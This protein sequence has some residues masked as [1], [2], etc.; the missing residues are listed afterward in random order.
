VNHGQLDLGASR[1][2]LEACEGRAGVVRRHDPVARGERGRQDVL[3]PRPGVGGVAVDT[4]VHS[5]EHAVRNQGA[6]VLPGHSELV[7]V[8]DGEEAE[9]LAG[10]HGDGP[11]VVTGHDRTVP[12]G[13]DSQ[14]LTTSPGN[15]A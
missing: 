14:P 1:D 4:A 6:A 12:T 9:Q 5:L 11:V 8:M 13:W 10:P 3:A 15:F 2:A 7:E